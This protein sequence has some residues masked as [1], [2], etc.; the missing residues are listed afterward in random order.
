MEGVTVRDE[1]RK[2]NSNKPPS[3]DQIVIGISNISSQVDEA[4]NR[5]LANAL[6]AETEK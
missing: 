1:E 2:R 4:D 6:P 5:P 3:P